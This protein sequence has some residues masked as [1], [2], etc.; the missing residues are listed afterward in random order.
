MR[1]NKREIPSNIE[2]TGTE[3]L[4]PDFTRREDGMFLMKGN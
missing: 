2:L 3:F 4:K 1:P